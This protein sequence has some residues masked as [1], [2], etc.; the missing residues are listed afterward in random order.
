MRLAG[1]VFI[2]LGLLMAYF[3]GLNEFVPVLI[4]AG[5]FLF[6]I[7]YLFKTCGETYPNEPC[8]CGESKQQTTHEIQHICTMHGHKH[9]G[10]KHK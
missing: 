3:V 9:N 4:G 10:H 7:N 1:C 5:I 8:S 2:C 6:I